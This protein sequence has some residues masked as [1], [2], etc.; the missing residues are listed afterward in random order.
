MKGR[1][2]NKH[3]DLLL[4]GLYFI[5]PVTGWQIGGILLAV[6]GVIVAYAVDFFSPKWKYDLTWKDI[7]LALYNLHRYGRDPSELCFFVENRKIYVY[8]DEKGGE[9]QPIRMSVRMPLKDWSDI[10]DEKGFDNLLHKF[11]GMG[12]YSKDR[13][14]ECYGIF[15][16]GG[17]E[18]CKEILRILFQKAVGG[19]RPEIMAQSTINTKKVIWLDHSHDE[20]NDS[21]RKGNKH[22]N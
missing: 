20:Q 22:S 15:P 16:K 12:L 13:G 10:F 6:I 9:K 4:L 18:D 7:D 14:P 1:A 8:R 2:K 21:L 11:S 17:L 3:Y 5:L 19:L